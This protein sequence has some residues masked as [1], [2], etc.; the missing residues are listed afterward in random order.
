[1]IRKSP[2]YFMLLVCTL[3]LAVSFPAESKQT[4][5]ERAVETGQTAFDQGS[6]A[7]AERFWQKAESEMR[8]TGNPDENLAHLLEQLGDCYCKEGKFSKAES[9]YRQSLEVRQGLSLE[10]TAAL[11][12]LKELAAFFRPIN[13]EGF[14]EN[15]TAFARQVGAESASVVKKDETHHID[16]NLKKRFQKGLKELLESTPAKT[17]K[18]GELTAGSPGSGQDSPPPVKQ[19]RL[20][21]QITFDLLRGD[22]GKLTLANIQ[23][24]FLNVG[25]WVKLKEFVMLVDND[26]PV[27]EVI[28]GAFGVD[29][30]VRI[31]LD[32]NLF[33]RLKQGLD[34]FDPFVSSLS[35]IP[36]SESDAG[37]A[38]AAAKTDAPVPEA[39]PSPSGSSLPPAPVPEP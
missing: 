34:K 4:Q 32:R 38:P 33:S 29:K 11:A 27:A 9:S 14:D 13:L 12:K 25:L 2:A 5:L 22:D 16:I 19:I 26:S 17:E 6:F 7:R 31:G 28:A 23:G 21:K 30:K 3:S 15:A 36:A 10:Q 37:S 35:Q 39:V 20:D 24:I 18:A 8:K 1:M